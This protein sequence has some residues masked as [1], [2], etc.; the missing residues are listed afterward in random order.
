MVSTKKEIKTMMNLF[1][2]L[3]PLTKGSLLMIAGFLLLLHTM[4]IL[5]SWIY[6]LLILGS[7]FM[8]VYGFFMAGLHH[9]IEK[10]I[11]KN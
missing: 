5:A 6:Y 4:G 10:L 9:K 3:S 11:R 2:N 1:K 7:I 8:I